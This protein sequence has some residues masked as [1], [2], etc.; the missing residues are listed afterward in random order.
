M[1]V[2]ATEVAAA[3]VDQLR[4]LS[5]RQKEKL[6][7]QESI[8]VGRE[9]R[10]QYLQQQQRQQQQFRSLRCDSQMRD[11]RL[12]ELRASMFGNRLRHRSD[13]CELSLLS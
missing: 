1:S 2:G 12:K 6:Q 5:A 3:S 13:S 11:S 9:Q 7:Q 8:I 4:A 10:L